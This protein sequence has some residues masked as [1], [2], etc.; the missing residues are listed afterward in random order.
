MDKLEILKVQAEIAN[1]ERIAETSDG[2]MRDALLKRAE[3][4]KKQLKDQGDSK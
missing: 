4:L 1:C 2:S 3:T